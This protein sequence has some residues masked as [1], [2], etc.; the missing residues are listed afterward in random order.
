MAI[1]F[2]TDGNGETNNP[3][4]ST[5]GVATGAED[6]DCVQAEINIV[7]TMKIEIASKLRLF[8]LMDSPLSYN[9]LG[10]VAHDV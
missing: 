4:G 6:K 7:D 9:Q 5:V 1:G 10:M 2:S 8:L 3:S